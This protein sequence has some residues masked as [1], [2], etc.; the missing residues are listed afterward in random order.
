MKIIARN[1]AHIYLFTLTLRKR[2]G[3]S[4]AA[5]RL[6]VFHKFFHSRLNKKELILKVVSS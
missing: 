6:E 4:L 2:C 1:L 3:F 5:K